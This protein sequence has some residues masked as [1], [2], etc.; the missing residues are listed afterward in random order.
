MFHKKY[1]SLILKSVKKDLQRIKY[2]KSQDWVL[3][4]SCDSQT[5]HQTSN[6]DMSLPL[7]VLLSFI[8]LV[9]FSK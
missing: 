1:F 2:C 7:V 5:K 6:R 9:G 4:L 3:I 8:I